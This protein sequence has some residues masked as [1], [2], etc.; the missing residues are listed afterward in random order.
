VGHELAPDQAAKATAL[1]ADGY[2]HETFCPV[3][4]IRRNGTEKRAVFNQRSVI[5]FVAA[6][7]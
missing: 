2:T 6:K 4:K 1:I 3:T 5:E 7:I